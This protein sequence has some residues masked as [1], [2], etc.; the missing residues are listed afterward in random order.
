MIVRWKVKYFAL[1]LV[2]VLGGIILKNLIVASTTPIRDDKG[3]I[4]PNSIALME[5]IEIGGMKQWILVRGNDESNPILLWL[6]GGPG[7]SQM[8][9]AH[10][11]DKELEK[12]FVVVHWDQ[13]G[14]GKS[15]P[16][17]FDEQTMTFEQFVS[18]THELTQYLKERYNREKIYLLGHSWG[19]QLGIKVASA[20][21]DDYYAYIGVSQVVSGYL[22]DEIGY[23]WLLE[24]IKKTGN[25]KD[26]QRLRKLGLPP[27]TDHKKYVHFAGMV[28]SYGGGMDA[29][30]THLMV[31]A[32]KAPEYNL[33]DY[34]HWFRGSMRGS[35]PMWNSTS[36]FNAFEEVPELSLPIYI[37]AGK[38]D[39]NTPFQLTDEYF[40]KVKAPKGKELVVFEQS[41]HTPFMAEPEKFNREILRVKEETYRK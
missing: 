26:L 22:S 14:A 34:I 9:V 29:D 3:N 37:F 6:H 7:S 4:I 27:F 32:L 33:I 24:K 19:A 12:H 38:K 11:F 10:Y 15:N 8:P 17:F 28:D 18:D 1:I 41:A 35:G 23:A 20:Y 39:Y 13:R 2:V 36:A 31:I 21:P 16:F 40:D 5:K 30:M 25:E